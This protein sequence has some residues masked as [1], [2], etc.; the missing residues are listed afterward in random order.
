MSS[1]P[2]PTIDNGEDNI[3]DKGSG[4]D[5]T[6]KIVYPGEAC[7]KYLN[8]CPKSNEIIINSYDGSLETNIAFLFSVFASLSVDQS[9]QDSQP[10]VEEFLCRVAFQPCDDKFVVHSPNQTTC[11]Y[12]RDELCPQDWITLQNTQFA[13]DL[14]PDCDLFSENSVSFTCGEFLASFHISI[15]WPKIDFCILKV[16]VKC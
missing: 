16:K 15:T 4:E 8:I 9:C 11:K 5:S 1:K 2:S 3:D 10:L 14:L 12:I 13:A 6:C 7:S